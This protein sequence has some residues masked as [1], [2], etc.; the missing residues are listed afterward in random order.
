MANMP[1]SGLTRITEGLV[2][3]YTPRLEKFIEDQ[4]AQYLSK[5]ENMATFTTSPQLLTTRATDILSAV[6]SYLPSNEIP[7]PLGQLGEGLRAIVR[8]ALPGIINRAVERARRGQVDA[9]K[10]IM[11]LLSPR[12]AVPLLEWL[13]TM[14][15]EHR[16]A[17][18]KALLAMGMTAQSLPGFLTLSV[19]ER[20]QMIDR[21]TPTPKTPAPVPVG[22]TTA[23]A[24]GTDLANTILAAAKKV[25][26]GVEESWSYKVM[27]ACTNPLGFFRRKRP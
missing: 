27:E 10:N 7:T 25:E 26:K 12:T 19:V 8:G 15:E 22:T 18:E 4:L 1:M 24:T 9:S 5:P 11:Q 3:Y 13:N 2:G 21:Y 14:N 6:F 17:V 20:E 16:I 23:A